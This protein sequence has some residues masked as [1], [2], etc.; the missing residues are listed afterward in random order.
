[1]MAGLNMVD[2]ALPPRIYRSHA[3][4]LRSNDDFI[5]WVIAFFVTVGMDV[6]TGIAA[7][8]ALS[9]LLL[10]RTVSKPN[11]AILGREPGK[12][13]YVNIGIG[14]PHLR[15]EL[16]SLN[17]FP[18]KDNLPSPSGIDRGSDVESI[19]ARARSRGTQGLVMARDICVFRFEARLFFA[20][21]GFLKSELLALPHKMKGPDWPGGDD[22]ATSP[23]SESERGS[24]D[25][26]MAT[27]TPILHVKGSAKSGGS[28]LPIMASG[29]IDRCSTAR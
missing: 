19:L 2:T 20:N 12:H 3:G 29:Y 4:R 26:A 9:I 13:T 1:M 6:T 8:M 22:T 14:S 21:A 10:V 11:T 7:S 25:L 28:P 18:A 23:L 24:N 27:L 17:T 15:R 5:V 16:A